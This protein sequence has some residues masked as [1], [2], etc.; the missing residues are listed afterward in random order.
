MVKMNK[1]TALLLIGF[2]AS[3]LASRQLLQNSRYESDTDDDERYG[4]GP[5]ATNGD[6][7]D[8]DEEDARYGGS[9]LPSGRY[10]GGSSSRYDAIAPAEEESRYGS[11][12]T[13][14]SRYGSEST[15]ASRYG[16]ESTSA[17]RYGSA[18]PSAESRYG[19]E[20]T[21]ASRYGSATPASRYGGSP[22]AE[23]SRYEGGS[24]AR[25][26]QG[27]RYEGGVRDGDSDARYNG[28]NNGG[29]YEGGIHEEEV[30]GTTITWR[31]GTNYAPLNVLVGDT[32]TFSW[33]GGSPHDVALSSGLGRCTDLEPLTDASEEGTF[34]V[35]FDEPG[36][37]VYA[38]SV[39]DHCLV[40][41]EIQIVAADPSRK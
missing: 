13:S 31:R 7:S 14:A 2:L 4:K 36:T 11:G 40:G 8:S 5:S 41:Q 3:A 19:S 39:G 30:E 15:S 33:S 21:S 25:Y 27:G 22:V 26:D 12:T 17:S 18:A 34:T 10:E 32:V 9:S 35:S 37:Y 16:S 6:L 20:S 24:S 28:A 23:G 38:C 1:L 29:R